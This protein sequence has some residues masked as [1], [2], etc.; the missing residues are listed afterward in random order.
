MTHRASW[1]RQSEKVFFG[2]V[3]RI[4]FSERSLNMFIYLST[5]MGTFE[6]FSG[7]KCTAFPLCPWN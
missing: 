4:A 6:L 5:S 1:A 3:Y 7:T 2:Q